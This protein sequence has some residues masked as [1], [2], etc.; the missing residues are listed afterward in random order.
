MYAAGY[1]EVLLPIYQTI[2]RRVSKD[3][4]LHG[5]FRENLEVHEVLIINKIHNFLFRVIWNI[6]LIKNILYYQIN[7]KYCQRLNYLFLDYVLT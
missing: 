5:H 7:H 4:N 1:Y 2:W 3:S 6:R